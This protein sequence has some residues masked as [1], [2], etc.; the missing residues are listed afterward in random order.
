MFDLNQFGTNG[1]D[2]TKQ[3]GESASI[4]SK[5]GFLYTFFEGLKSTIRYKL[6]ALILGSILAVVFFGLTGNW[7]KSKGMADHAAERGASDD[8]LGF[9][10]SIAS[11]IGYKSEMTNTHPFYNTS[12]VRN[13]ESKFYVRFGWKIKFEKEFKYI[14]YEGEDFFVMKKA[15]RGKDKEKLSLDS[16]TILGMSQDDYCEDY[17]EGFVPRKELEDYFLDQTV[18]S[19]RSIN[20]EGRFRCVIG[21]DTVEEFLEDDE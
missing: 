13:L 8:Y 21:P 11:S 17:F 16:W 9:F 1:S 7:D 14:K 20:G 19:V 4:F 15:A 3:N 6:L 10:D 5:N 2:K 12:G 18:W